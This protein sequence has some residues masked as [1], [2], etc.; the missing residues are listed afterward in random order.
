[1]ELGTEDAA[2][3]MQGNGQKAPEPRLTCRGAAT[4]QQPHPTLSGL[5]EISPHPGED[6]GQR[7]LWS[8]NQKLLEDPG[9]EKFVLF[10][11][12]SVCRLQVS[13]STSR[14]LGLIGSGYL[15]STPERAIAVSLQK[16]E[17]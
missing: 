2:T 15:L 6:K 10:L 8:Q 13:R 3:T 11:S 7:D 5:M 12:S 14:Y 4:S 1:M 17:K 16:M 9:C